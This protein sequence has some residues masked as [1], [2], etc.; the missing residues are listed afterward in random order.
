MGNV[1]I[2]N[3]EKLNF[4]YGSRTLWLIGLS[5]ALL[6]L[7]ALA[8][9]VDPVR[10]KLAGDAVLN[11]TAYELLAELSDEHGA[12]MIGTPAHAASLDVLESRLHELELETRRQ[13]FSFPGWV[14][15]DSDVRMLEPRE[16]RIR[17]AALGYVEAQASVEGP[18]AYVETTDLDE[19]AER[20]LD[21]RI[22]LVKHNLSFS[23]EKQKQLDRE[24][25]VRGVLY[26]NRVTGGQLLAK[27]ANH[28]GTAA[29]F[30][31]FTI[32]QEQGMW[33]QRL[34]ESG[35][36]VRLR[37]KTGG[38]IKTMTGTNLIANL[39]GDSGE[40]IVLGG[41]FDSWDLGQ[42]SIDNG[43]GVVQI[44]DAARLLR[45]HSPDNRHEIEFVWFDAEE[46][47]LWG[48]YHYTEVSPLEDVRAMINLDMV[49]RPKA[50]NAM[51]FDGLVPALNEYVETLGSW[52]FSRKVSNKPWL[53]SD[54]HPF[55]L[56]G[57]P[58][59]TF[60]APMNEEDVRY[61]HDFGD[62][63]DKI[64]REMLGESTALIALLVYHLANEEADSTLQLSEAETV[65]LLREA[66]LEERLRKAGKWPFDNDVE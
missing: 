41:H 63:L 29:P 28:D 8:E 55:I 65:E 59:I 11:D 20:D 31:L 24:H 57:V 14:R 30:P 47:G 56:K 6:S 64:D 13:T 48:A 17:A 61:Y 39:P 32:T 40:K 22:L 9:K 33:M 35:K 25:G 62:S 27:A 4:G 54:H 26:I 3:T 38:R 15:G 21:G 45:E 42:G 37:L 5:L 66:G 16:I 36:T 34:V 19:L 49:G 51:G 10:A 2:V 44:F 53:G 18:V 23:A 50:I 12:R 43:V 58:A 46:F 60:N 1:A 7:G 52:E